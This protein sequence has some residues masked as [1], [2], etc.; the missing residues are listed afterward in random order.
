MRIRINEMRVS[1][2][3]ECRHDMRELGNLVGTKLLEGSRGKIASGKISDAAVAVAV[4]P[5]SSLQ[6]MANAIAA[7]VWNQLMESGG[8]R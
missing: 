3:G 8:R 6:E 4:A 2:R 1:V 5:N 7:A